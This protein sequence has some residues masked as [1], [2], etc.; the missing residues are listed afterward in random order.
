MHT[1][2]DDYPETIQEAIEKAI[3]ETAKDGVIGNLAVDPDSVTVVKPQPP[4]GTF[5]FPDCK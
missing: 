4:E 5:S 1:V 2:S 3:S